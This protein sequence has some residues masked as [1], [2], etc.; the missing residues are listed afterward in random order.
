VIG[1]GPIGCE[2]AQAFRRFGAEVFV[3]SIDPQI[4][5]REDADAANL[6]HQ[7]LE[8]E[9][10]RWF[11]GA[12]IRHAEKSSVG[13]TIV[14]ERGQGVEHVTA[15]EIL[16]AVGRTPNVEGMN[17]EVA[18][19]QYHSK[20]V[21]VDDHL[22]TT[23][24]RIYAAGDICSSYQFTHAAEALARIAL[25]NAL[26][27]GRKKANDL[28]IPW[29]SYT[30]PEIAHV[31]LSSTEARNSGPQVGTITLPLGSN[32]RAI[33]DGETDGFLRVHF[34][35]E[36]GTILGATLVSKHA[37]ESIGELVLAIQKKMKV[38]D[39]SNTIHPYPT[40][41]EIIKRLG[42]AALRT[43]LKPWMKKLLEKMLRLRR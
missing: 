26:F 33:V 21:S 7:Q 42:D 25:Q 35:A 2:L 38:W 3:V 14:F 41:A 30:D 12:H 15:D 5:P 37:G 31:G 6:L 16:V 28:V 39:L 23:N 1:A 13:K 32:D 4:L 9:G 10:V 40:Q 22:R 27:F 19:V 8:R 18:G 24:P 29:C 17:L 43:R 11:L 20:G 36:K 34:N